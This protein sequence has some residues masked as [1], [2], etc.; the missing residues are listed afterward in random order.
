LFAFTVQP[1]HPLRV[2]MASDFLIKYTAALA[3]GVAEAGAAVTLLTRD[4]DLEFGG[5]PGAMREHVSDRLGHRGAH[6]EVAGRIREPSAVVSL[7]QA[8]R[9]IWRFDPQVIHLQDAIITDPRLV[10]AAQARPGRFAFTVHD[11]TRHPGG[12][13]P[14]ARFE[15]VR[16]A[17]IK[18]AGVIFVHAQALREELAEKHRPRAPI[19]VVPHGVDEPVVRPLPAEPSLLFFGRIMHYKGLDT[20]LDAMPMIW[21]NEPSVSLVVAGEGAIPP[22]P[23]LEDRRITVRNSH[24]PENEVASLYGR[25][26]CVVLPYRQASQSG[27]G[28]LALAHGRGLI[29]TEVGG[30]PD[31]VRGGAGRSVPPEDPAA[32]AA[33]I[34]EVVSARPVADAMGRAAATAALGEATW[35]RVGQRTLEAYRRYLLP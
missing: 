24:V 25:A 23:A 7:G 10:L 5:V 9:A 11:P 31:L 22:H 13:R 18:T 34:S 12:N 26:S 2:V 6:L 27:V 33:A 1:E 4:H 21:E 14:R 3:R 20:L 8:G 28:S 30:L 32:L 17:L 16:K 35:T 15:I 19:V 29:V